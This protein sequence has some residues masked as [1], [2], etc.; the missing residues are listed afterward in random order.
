MDVTAPEPE[1]TGARRSTATERLSALA[2]V[3]VLAYWSFW[4]TPVRPASARVD[5]LFDIANWA[6]AG[7]AALLA[8]AAAASSTRK[9]HAIGPMGR[10]AATVRRLPRWAIALP[11]SLAGSYVVARMALT[12]D[13]S[14]TYWGAFALWAGSIATLLASFG[15]PLSFR[16][17]RLDAWRESLL[18]AVRSEYAL[19]AA[20]T[21]VALV[22][23][24]T[25][26]SVAPPLIHVDEEAIGFDAWLAIHGQLGDPFGISWGANPSMGFYLIGAFLRVFGG[27]IVSVRL[28]SAVFGAAAIPMMYLLLREMFGRWQ[29]LAGAVFILGY[30]LHLQFSRVGLN[31]VWDTPTMAA[32]MYFAY[33][34]SRDGQ[35]FD[36]AASG[37]VCGLALYLY[38]GTRV[39]PVVIFLYF[40]YMALFRWRFARD[41]A[42]HLVLAGLAFLVAG[43]PIIAFYM[44]DPHAF[45]AR[46]DDIGIFQ[47]SWFDQQRAL[48]RSGESILWS[49]TRHAFGGWFYYADT[50]PFFFYTPSKPLLQGLAVIPLIAGIVY[51]S[52]HIDDRRYALLIVGF[53]VPT[54]IGGALTIGPPNAQRLF[55][56]VP[57]VVA[58]I[59]VGL[60]QLGQRILG[61]RPALVGAVTVLSAASL[62]SAGAWTYYSAAQGNLQ[63]GV[64]VTTVAERYILSLPAETRVYWFG[65]PGVTA[66]FSELTMRGRHPIEVFDSVPNAVKPVTRASPSA[67]VFIVGRDA[68][69]QG[70]MNA[71][72]GGLVR[73]VSF[74]GQLILR[75]YELKS[76]NTC[77]PPVGPPDT[78]RRAIIIAAAPVTDFAD[79][80]N[81]QT[82]PGEPA[83]PCGSSRQ[84]IWYAFTPAADGTI[85]ANTDGSLVHTVLTAYTGASDDGLHAIACADAASSARA[86][87]QFPATTGTTYYFQIG[88]SADAVLPSAVIQFNLLPL[89]PSR[90]AP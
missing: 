18:A 35:A 51:S 47:S 83:P 10:I 7:A 89:Q 33:R 44:T 5:V 84:P 60:W 68:R 59:S 70:V 23:R 64:L 25:W 14:A 21:A 57:S 8:L 17:P 81:A 48:G 38:H 43:L 66:E 31:V 32:A 56:A 67:Y 46:L 55:G 75:S 80:T 12:P 50:S 13:S 71:C 15:E 27:D 63:Y 19:V 79:N 39:V 82:Q 53:V 65:A 29:A 3:S 54:F 58:L 72:P 49:Q 1:W 90:A 73:T 37:V 2:A 61:M 76:A 87:V 36:F 9:T 77:R 74:K 20:L 22:M 11:P 41:H 62:A 16:L 52:L 69:I 85:V 34:A 42:G 86:E 6:V 45:W 28:A 26:L 30:D 78:V 24:A 88:S 40:A 4:R